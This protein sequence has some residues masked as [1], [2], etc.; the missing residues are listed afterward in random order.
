MKNTFTKILLAA[1]VLTGLYFWNERRAAETIRVSLRGVKWNGSQL[2]LILQV[3][4]PTRVAITVN[5]IF[6]DL[7]YNGNAFANVV[8]FQPQ[9]VAPGTFS[10]IEVALQISPLGLISVLPILRNAIST[11]FKNMKFS[12]VGNIRAN[13]IVIP[14]KQ[15]TTLFAS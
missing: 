3:V 4:N 5:S 6:G 11:G 13:G 14:L 9:G 7:I 15:E 1:G 2:R 8:N 10:N 12:F